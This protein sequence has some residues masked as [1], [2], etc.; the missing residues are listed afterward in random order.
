[1]QILVK[2]YAG[3]KLFGTN[4]P[5]SDLD[6]RGIYLPEYEDVVMQR[7]KDTIKKNIKV[8]TGLKNEAGDVDEEYYSIFKFLSM[9]ESG[10]TV[11]IELLFTPESM[12]LEKHPFWDKIVRNRELL[13]TKNVSAMAGY[14]RQQ[15][16]KYGARGGRIHTFGEVIK[17]LRTKNLND[18]LS[19][20][21]TELEEKFTEM[22][23]I[24]F[25]KNDLQHN[26]I[27]F[28]VCG[29]KFGPKV[30]V[31]EV[32][33]CIEKAHEEYGERAKQAEL[34][35]NIDLKS[36]SHGVR[37]AL[38]AIELLQDH[39]I[40]LPLKDAVLVKKIK[41]G[42]MK[43]N[44]MFPLLDDLVNK[45]FELEKTSTLPDKFNKKL[46][47]EIILDYYNE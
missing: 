26:D 33:K 18:K 20:F 22:E 38:Q 9:L 43:A 5:R 24:L 23:H 37:V 46:M 1:M 4:G 17:F 47:E 12:I 40:T 10:Q 21:W 19:L 32:L 2:A 42:E 39:K 25:H 8:S 31:S 34:N 30:V 29:K 41:E 28:D 36:V 15:V 14:I 6:I 13:L 35:Q 11:A 45:V 27:L 7:T 3:S 16:N 44:E